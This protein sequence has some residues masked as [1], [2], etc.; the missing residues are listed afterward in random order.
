V[1]APKTSI[2]HMQKNKMIHSHTPK[3]GK[4]M[5]KST[6]KSSDSELFVVLN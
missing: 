6:G 1:A 4:Y 3:N 2:K 5:E